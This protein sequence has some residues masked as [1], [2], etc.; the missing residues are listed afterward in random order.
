[1]TEAFIAAHGTEVANIIMNHLPPTGWSDRATRRDLS[2]T[3][4]VLRSELKSEIA[5][6]R[7]ELKS[8]ISGLR[9]ELKSEISGLRDEL[10]SEVSGLRSELK[11]EISG[12]RDEL[13]SEISG[14]RN[15]MHRGF[16]SMF[17][18][19]VG[20]MIGMSA[21][22]VAGMSLVATIIK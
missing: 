22:M 14:L 17:K 13:K 18:W 1:M 15:E 5:D 9:D 21:V 7:D 6:L 2:E 11:S 20:T 3:A 19:V 10:K 12:L 8:E 4:L 16:A